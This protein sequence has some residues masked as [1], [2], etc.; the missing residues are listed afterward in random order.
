LAAQYLCG[1]ATLT[2]A[3]RMMYAFA[4]DGGM[5]FSRLL[6]RVSPRRRCPSVAIWTAAAITTAFA[7]ALPYETVAAIFAIFLY[8][9]YVLPTALSLRAHG[10]TWTRMG[11]WHVG[12]W[13][14]PLAL[15]CIAGCT[16]LI[17][18][19]VQPPNDIAIWIVGGSVLMLVIFWWGY[20]ARRFPGP[21]QVI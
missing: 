14:R 2:S 5:P 16:L 4:R 10:R 20:M 6:R 9:A 3:S 11:P 12:C 17:V 18:V 21:P 15:L 7:V 19:G 1:L 13:Y 8:L